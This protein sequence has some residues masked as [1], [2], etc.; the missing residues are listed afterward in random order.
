MTIVLIRREKTDTQ[1]KDSHVLTEA[2]TGVMR[3]QGKE[4]QGW[5]QPSEGREFFSRASR[6]S[7][8]LTTSSFQTA[9]LQNCES[10][11]SG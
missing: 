6:G 3:P 9:R 11:N 5:K 8:A 2:E 1:G 10:I 4:C 7:V